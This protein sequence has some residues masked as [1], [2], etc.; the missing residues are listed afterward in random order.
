[1]SIKAFIPISI[2]GTFGDA[3]VPKIAKSIKA[4]FLARFSGMGSHRCIGRS[5]SSVAQYPTDR[6][7]WPIHSLQ[8]GLGVQ[9]FNVAAFI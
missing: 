6:W 9:G 3:K 8:F 1:M 5:R 4:Y 7:A 2:F